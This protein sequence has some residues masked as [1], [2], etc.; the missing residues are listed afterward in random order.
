MSDDP[1]LSM[2]IRIAIEA[3]DLA[4]K[5][6]LPLTGVTA[7]FGHSGSG[8]TTLLRVFAGLERGA[9]GRIAFNGE[10]WQDTSPNRVFLP[11]EQRA[12]GYVFQ[13]ARLFPHL[14]VAGNL[15]FAEQRASGRGEAI[16]RDAVLARFGLEPLLDRHPATLSGGERQRVAIARALLTRPRLLLM[17]EPLSALDARRRAEILPYIA[18]LPADFGV[19]VVYV[20]HA[21]DEVAYLADSMIV[22][23][24]GRKVADGPVAETLARLDLGPATGRFEAGVVLEAI[25]ARH[26]QVYH[27]TE[28]VLGRAALFVPLIDAPA[29]TAVR[30]RVRARDV[31][32][33]VRRPEEITSRNILEGKI[34]EIVEEPETAFAETLVDVEGGRIRAR[35]TR[36]AV[37][38]LHLTAGVKVF[39]VIKSISLAGGVS[40]VVTAADGAV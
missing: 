28:L 32:L 8:K 33:A 36:Q 13:D 25:V 26:D 18:R 5:H 19:P 12:V 27:L 4:V 7:L 2:E 9:E 15:A 3:F 6:E 16:E 31:A 10:V 37:A 35:V 24:E 17:D 20:T 22:L 1:V 11:P 40:T 21:V 39:A 34:L 14:T 29:G 30:L 38:E 23:S